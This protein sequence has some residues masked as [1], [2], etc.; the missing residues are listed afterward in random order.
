VQGLQD[1][2]LVFWEIYP[3]FLKDLFVEAFARGIGHPDQRVREGQWRLAMNRLR[4]SI[5]YCAACRRQNFYDLDRVRATAGDPGECWGCGKKLQVPPR[6]RVGRH[7]VMLNHD[8]ELFPHHLDD[9]SGYDFTRPFARVVE[10]PS[11]PG[12]WG[13]R[14]LTQSHWT[15][16]RADGQTQQVNPGQSVSLNDRAKVHFGDVEAEIRAA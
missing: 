7:L 11:R 4:D 9:T 6:I 16:F 1:N 2:A 3:K 14:N 15:T 8:A 12:L 10:H 13:L 5:L